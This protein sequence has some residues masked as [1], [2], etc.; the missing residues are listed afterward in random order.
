MKKWIFFGI[1]MVLGAGIGVLSV[2]RH[3]RKLAFDE[4]NEARDVFRKMSASKE[5]ANRNDELKKK[6]IEESEENGQEKSGKTGKVVQKSDKNDDFN[7]YS[8]IIKSYNGEK[9]EKSDSSRHN[10]NVF[11]NPPNADEIDISDEEEE[12]TDDPYELS[13]EHEGPKE[14]GYSPPYHITEEEFA[15]EKL[16][17]DKVM[18]EYYDDGVAVLED[19]NQIIDCI[20]DLVGPDILQE[21]LENSNWIY[22]DN[23]TYIRNDSRSSDYGIIF[24]GTDYVPE[25]GLN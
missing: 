20:E 15:S 13:V 5:A 19:S 21:N 12:E 22:N 14:N 18:I 1:G 11:S 7:R 3:Y 16:F 6:L 9:S 24:M 8:E 4:I 25:E 10:Y 2:R 23:E 17:Y